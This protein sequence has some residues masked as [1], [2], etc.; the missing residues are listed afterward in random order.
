MGWI[1]FSIVLFLAYWFVGRPL[2]VKKPD[3]Q[4]GATVVTSVVCTLMIVLGGWFGAMFYADPGYN[5]QVRTITGTIKATTTPGWQTKWFGTTYPWKKA[6]SVA[7]TDASNSDEATS[8]T[9]PPYTIRM[10][11]RVDGL[12]EQTTRFRLPSDPETFLAMVAEYR[13]PANLLATELIPTV[14]Q[15]ITANSSLMGAEDYFNGKR[16]DFQMDFVTQMREGIF[17]VNRKEVTTTSSTVQKSEADASAKGGKQSNYGDQQQ[18]RFVVEKMLNPDGSFR[19]NK[20]NYHNFGITVVDAKITDFDPNADFKT[21]MKDQQKASADRAIAREQ[22][23]EEEEKRQ[24]AVVRSQ[25]EQAEE[26]GKVL[27]AQIKVTTEA[28]TDKKLALITANK[29]LEQAEI[30][31]QAA[32]IQLDRDKLVAQS[33]NV[34]A[35]ADKY[36]REARIA[37]DG[38]L[39]QKLAA[40]VEAQKVWADASAKRAVP[41]NVTVLGGGAG[42]SNGVPT[43]ANTEMQTLTQLMSVSLAKQLNVDVNVTK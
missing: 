15:V 22:K 43:G 28:E 7:H 36:E 24:L 4:K 8:S 19:V 26:Q 16:N 12:V 2:L 42:A 17:M 10:L 25:R 1:I 18:T 37:G 23:I 14:E 32:Q 35:D 40:W 5:Y 31:K 30:E 34:L 27:K 38:A 29:L 9:L 13:T 3:M 39:E 20:H 33:K 21:R 6:M 11:D 41:T